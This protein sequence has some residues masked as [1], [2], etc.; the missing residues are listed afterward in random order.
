MRTI[1]DH[2]QDPVACRIED[3]GDD[4]DIGEV[5]ASVVRRV[6]HEDIAGPQAS[7]VVTQHCPNA[8]AHGPEVHG[9]VR[10]ICDQVAA[11]I[12]QRA[13]E[14]E[15]LLDVDRVRRVLQH[16][17]HLLGDVHEV[18]VEYLEKDRVGCRTELVA[19]PGVRDVRQ[20]EPQILVGRHRPAGI[21]DGRGGLVDNHR[22]AL[23]P[24]TRNEVSALVNA[25]VSPRTTLVQPGARSG[26]RSRS[27]GDW[28]P[29]TRRPLPSGRLDP[30]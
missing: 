30:Q 24:V 1:G 7:R 18:T 17:A 26:R 10:R 8:V 25:R 27:L 29:D 11:A 21:H 14:V 15:S 28:S 5:R 23:Q 9:H 3:R 13:R 16:R 2:E 19:A 22:R 20:H 4:G 6:Q 12:E